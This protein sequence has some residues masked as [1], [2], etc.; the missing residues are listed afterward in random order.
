LSYRRADEAA[1][2]RGAAT[3]TVCT[4]HLALCNLVKDVLPIAVSDAVGDA[5]LLIPKM[6]ELEHDG[7]ALATVDAGMLPQDKT[8]PQA[9]RP[10]IRQ[11]E[12]P[13]GSGAVW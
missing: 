1:P 9:P 5:E 4:N 6:V 2:F 12:D 3:V 7:I 8:F 10:S 13:T 11:N